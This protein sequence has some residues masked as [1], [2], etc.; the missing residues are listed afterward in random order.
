MKK[1]KHILITLATAILLIADIAPPIVYANETNKIV[2]EQ[3]EIQKAVDEIDEKLSQPINISEAELNARI[4]EAKE[5]YPDLTEERMKELAYQTLTPYS[6][7]ASVW[8]GKGVTLSEFAWVVENLIAS[9]ISGGVA[10]IG[11]LVK[12]R[13]L[14]AARA[15]LSRVA[16]NA[17][18]RLGIYSN[19]L[20]VILDRAFDYIN[21]F[22]NVGYGLAKYVD[23]IDFHKNN[24]RINAWP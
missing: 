2:N 6:Y 3:Q 5:R 12:K 19:W 20:G 17:A 16:K 8:D 11:N 4:S 24:G 7:R 18:I 14:A 13:G 10:G 1:I 15:T 23:S 22:Y 21:I 9:A